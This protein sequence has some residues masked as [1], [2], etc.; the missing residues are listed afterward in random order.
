[1]RLAEEKDIEEIKSIIKPYAKTYFSHIRMDYI[2]RCVR[3]KKVLLED[4]VVIIFGVYQRKQRIGNVYA[5]RGDAHIAQI[6][7]AAQGSGKASEVLQ[8]FFKDMSRNVWLT[9]RTEN[10]R[11]CAFYV[12]N[13]MKRVGD[14]SWAK[15]TV[16]GSVFLYTVDTSL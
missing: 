11:A 8:R 1:M 12:K 9:V 13:G 2:E 5:H 3:S 4:G 6:A 10:A 14:T 7:T 16:P 15:G